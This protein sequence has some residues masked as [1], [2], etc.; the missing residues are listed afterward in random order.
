MLSL[1]LPAGQEVVL[2]HSP[3]LCGI[4]EHLPDHFAAYLGVGGEFAFHDGDRAVLIDNNQIGL[5]GAGRKLPAD[6]CV[7]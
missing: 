2:R 5:S 1:F 6:A 4:V 3:Q 7:P